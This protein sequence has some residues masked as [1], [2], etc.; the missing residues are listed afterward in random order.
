[1]AAP[2]PRA[3]ASD[4]AAAAPHSATA[5]FALRTTD[6]ERTLLACDFAS[7]DRPA[8]V[9]ALLLAF[10]TKPDGTPVEPVEVWN[11]P[12]STRHL[13]LVR[14]S[15]AL[16]HTDTFALQLR[17]PHDDCRELLEVPLAIAALTALHDEHAAQKNLAM[18]GDG[19]AT[20]TLR[21]PTG[22]DL[23]RW[24]AAGESI[25]HHAMLRDLVLAGET[26]ADPDPLTEALE[27]FDPLLAFTLSLTCPSCGRSADHLVDLEALALAR[28]QAR[29]TL[30]L[31]EIH[32]LAGAYGWTESEIL[33]V[34][35]AR[36]VRYLELVEAASS[37]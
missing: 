21:R 8:L 16:D 11:L 32:R 22:D 24:R 9:T 19:T 15:T 13:S 14:I 1:M 30:L 29:Q 12:V 3:D 36:R 27:A 10:L 28:L 37:P 33:A 23:R 34:P 35:A 5:A 20:S 7:R 18:P 26:P 25:A 17:C 2:A 6:W 31:R 4:A